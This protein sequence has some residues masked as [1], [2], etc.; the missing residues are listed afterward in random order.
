MCAQASTPPDEEL[1]A[2]ALDHA[3]RGVALLDAER[4]DQL[5]RGLLLWFLADEREEDEF[6][7]QWDMVSAIADS[8]SGPVRVLLSNYLGALATFDPDRARAGLI[9]AIPMS[10]DYGMTGYT[11]R[12]RSH[13]ALLDSRS[14]DHARAVVTLLELIDD[15][16][17]SGGW[18][19]AYGWMHRLVIV[20][21]NA[22][23]FE[24]AVTLHHAIPTGKALTW[25]GDAP[26][27]LLATALTRLGDERY[28]EL[29]A[30]GETLDRAG[31][32]GYL[33]RV[34]SLVTAG[35]DA[36]TS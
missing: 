8:A 18:R 33:H 1:W 35:E 28:R 27:E 21:G 11:W 4:A 9:E 6:F 13:L 31:L 26:A 3:R 7:E 32:H 2:T 34:A 24:E 30:T 23:L 12:L 15:E 20:L 16:I 19:P 25:G 10:I 14:G 36:I 5:G 22:G 17:A 29:V